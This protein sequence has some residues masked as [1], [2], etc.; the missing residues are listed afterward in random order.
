[1]EYFWWEFGSCPIGLNS[2]CGLRCAFDLDC[3]LVVEPHPNLNPA[4][5]IIFQFDFL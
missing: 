3:F 5:K 2:S 4:R 1:M